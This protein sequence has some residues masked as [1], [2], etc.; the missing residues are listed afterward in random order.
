MSYEPMDFTIFGKAVNIKSTQLA[1][2]QLYRVD[3]ERDELYYDVYLPSFPEGTNPIFRERTEHDCNCCKAFIRNFGGVVAIINGERHSIWDVEV[4]GFYQVVADAMAAYV[5]SKPIV[6]EF[7]HR[8]SRVG[9]EETVSLTEEYGTEVHNH[10][11]F[12][13]PSR[14]VNSEPGTKLSHSKADH[15]VLKRSVEELSDSSLDLVLEWIN[16]DQ[17]YRGAEYKASVEALQ[18]C[19]NVTKNLEGQ[20]Y[21]DKIWDLA[22]EL[23]HF[24]RV[25]NNAMGTLLIDLTEGMEAEQAVKKFEAMVA[26]HNY[27]RSKTLATP[28]QIARAKKFFEENGYMSALERRHA[29]LSDISINDVQFADQSARKVMLDA[30]DVL[31]SKIS[32]KTPNLDRVTEIGASDFLARVLPGARAVSVLFEEKN[33]GNLMTLLAPKDPESKNMLKWN[34]NF[35][36][37]YNGDVA[38]STM[39]QRVKDAGGQVDGVLRFS[40]QWNDLT[41][42]QSDLDAHCQEPNRNLIYYP[43]RGRVQRSSGMLDV[44][45]VSP[46]R[47]VAV[48]NIIHTDINRMP[49][50][51]YDYYVHVYSLSATNDGFRAEIEFDG[52]IFK[53]NYT[54]SFKQGQKIRVATVTKKGSNFTIK[55]HMAFGE[56]Q[57]PPKEIWNITTTKYVKVDSIMYS[58]NYWDGQ[59]IGNE[60]IF[61]ILNGCKNPDNVRGFFNEQL[62]A[63]MMEHRKSLEMLGN[64]TKV[65]YAEDQ[66]S[67]LGFNFTTRNDLVVKVEGSSVQH[68]KIK[69]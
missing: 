66:M 40:I 11:W 61:F 20:A 3:L 8:E 58:P 50:G 39:K 17:I 55:T 34:N 52:Q 26:P 6:N 51:E 38:D 21:A 1:Q 2:A 27:K 59:E 24:G 47:N 64:V 23:G 65:P 30:F 37:A 60:Q 44:D 54:G 32:D 33:K 49:D 36:W 9:K 68:Y 12:D 5:K 25:R 4:G 19:K 42:G 43:E 62:N 48:E 13:L 14:Y 16:G 46:G 7:L 56:G 22:S 63:E 15:D 29:T 53:F 41:G 67:G 28:A 45:I 69:F 10:F 35:T 31:E 18:R 57:L